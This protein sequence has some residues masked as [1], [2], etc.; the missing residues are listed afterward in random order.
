M[1]TSAALSIDDALD[2][3]MQIDGAKCAALVD[4]QSGMCLGTRGDG[5][6]DVELAAAGNTELVRA[7]RDV[8]ASLGLDD[9]IEDMLISLTNQYHL[10]KIFQEN[11]N[12]F[13]YIVVDRDSA[14]LGL[15]RME[16]V[17]IDSRLEL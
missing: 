9:E 6:I 3:A 5:S 16:L 11:E 7:K 1:T 12:I 14:N 4:F 13:S 2:K 10:I 15:A 8:I 17:D